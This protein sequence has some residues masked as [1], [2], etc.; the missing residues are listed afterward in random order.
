[1]DACVSL[2][3]LS[4]QVGR[5][6]HLSLYIQF[7]ICPLQM[8]LGYQRKELL[9]TQPNISIVGD[10]FPLSVEEGLLYC[11]RLATVMKKVNILYN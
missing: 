10:C 4:P 7:H 5:K 2:L 6:E 1:M 9:S 8:R 3:I 11:N